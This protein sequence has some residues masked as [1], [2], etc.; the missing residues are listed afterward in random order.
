M[1]VMPVAMRR[2]GA[3]RTLEHLLTSDAATVGEWRLVFLEN[4]P[5]VEEYRTRGVDVEVV[6]AG[7]LRQPHRLIA[8]CNRLRREMRE[9]HPSLVLSWMPKA[10]FYAGPAAAAA[11][12]PCAWYQH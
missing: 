9:W 4:G 10:H 5:M 12:R 8:C 3:E 6:P 7:R 11:R 2:G 1:V